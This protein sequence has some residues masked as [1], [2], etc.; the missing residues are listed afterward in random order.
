MKTT[1]GKHHQDDADPDPGNT[2]N[3][4]SSGYH[5]FEARI[6]DDKTNTGNHDKNNT[7]HNKYNQIRSYTMLNTK[8]KR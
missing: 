1:R 4:E 8:S 7:E 5:S 6:A 3:R 2:T